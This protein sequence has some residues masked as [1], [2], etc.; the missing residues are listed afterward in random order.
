LETAAKLLE[1]L[2]PVLTIFFKCALKSLN[3]QADFDS[4]IRR[5]DP[6][7]PSQLM[8]LANRTLFRRFILNGFLLLILNVCRHFVH[9]PVRVPLA[10]RREHALLSALRVADVALLRPVC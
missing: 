3:N 7:R 4:A 8:L 1:L 6:S 5:F 2:E 10:S 9:Q